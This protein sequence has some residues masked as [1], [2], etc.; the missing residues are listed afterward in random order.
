[1]RDFTAR[2]T[3]RFCKYIVGILCLVCLC[4]CG[5]RFAGSSGNR[6]TAGQSIWV[7]FI[8]NEST[9]SLAQTI[10]RRALLDEC[11]HLRGLS[12]AG[13]AA[14]AEL[15]V[16][17]SST[18]QVGA[19]SYTAADQVKQYRLNLGVVVELK[20]KG[21][22]TPLWKGALQAYQDFPVSTDLSLQRSA[23]EAALV[24]AS[25]TLAQ[26]FLTAVEQS[27]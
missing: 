4:G 26:K 21:E 27:Y 17:G 15:S 8:Q 22:A 24:A 20:R 13:D 25:R 1:M 5:Y 9:N 2:K 23:E 3:G 10:I 19:V 11:H 6:I 16:V 7:A 14:S 18:Y 12:P